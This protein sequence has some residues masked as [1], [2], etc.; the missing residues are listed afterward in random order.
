MRGSALRACAQVQKYVTL[1][2]K[3]RTKGW[4]IR[5]SAPADS[6]VELYRQQ[7][8][9]RLIGQFFDRAV[10]YA[11][12]GYQ[13]DASLR[14]EHAATVADGICARASSDPAGWEKGLKSSL[15]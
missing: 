10:C 3:R 6:A 12:E 1:I 15:H 11:A 7:E 2:M 14:A 9:D 4:G 8:L 5:A 13:R